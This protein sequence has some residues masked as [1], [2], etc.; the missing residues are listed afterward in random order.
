MEQDILDLLKRSDY[1]PANIAGIRQALGLKT[2]RLTALK[3][4]VHR[5]ERN[6][7][8][9]RI[10]G[11]RYIIPREAD[12]V[13]GRLQVTRSGRGFLIPDDES[14]EEVAIPAESTGT[15]L[16]E[17]KVLARINP[18]SSRRGGIDQ[19]PSGVVVRVLERRRSQFVGT[20]GRSRQ[21]V[22][23]I[24]DDPR[25]PYDIYVPEPHDVGRPA[26]AGDKVVV[27]LTEWSSAHTRPEGEV[28]EVL[29]EATKEGVDM[30]SVIR[31]YELPLHFPKP[32]LDEVKTLGTSVNGNDVKGRVD[33]RKHPVIT[34]DPVDAK[35]FDDAFSLVATSDGNWKLMVHIADV[36]Y[37]VKRGSPLDEEARK[38]GNSTYLVDRVI[39]M[40]PEA[41]SNELCSLKPQ[42]DRL[43][44]CVEFTL[45]PK[46]NVLRSKCL[47]AVIHSQHRYTYEEA[48]SVLERKPEND[49]EQMLHAASKLA[50]QIRKRRFRS[51]A[52]ELEFPENKIYLDAQGRVDR[53]VQCDY[54]VSHQLIE[55]FMLLANEAVAEKLKRRRTPTVYRIHEA[56]DPKRL[57]DY[58]ED[59]KAH[60]IPCGNL[61]KPGEVQKLMR[62][63]NESNVGKA[64]KIGFLKALM[65]ARYSTAPVG[66]YGLAKEDYTHFT[67]PIRRYADL[68]VHRSLFEK[69]RQA[70]LRE[71]SDHISLT[72]R[73]SA[74]AER[75]SHS[76]KLFAHLE[77]QLATDKRETYSGLITEIR[78]FGFFVDVSALGLSG[79]VPLSSVEDEFF[80]FHRERRLLVGQRTGRQIKLGDEIE[81][82]VDKVDA[83]KKQVDFRL[84]RSPG[85]T[86]SKESRSWPQGSKHKKLRQGR[87]KRRS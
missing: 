79:L 24:P 61:N 34:I 10:K 51:G 59:V 37:Y 41:L 53:I 50:Q 70:D 12:L 65:R 71:I 43:T 76:V 66:H 82:E 55:E 20:L 7:A 87:R 25:I 45:D 28:I 52:L 35:D 73:N 3:A 27:E 54:D 84:K 29:G 75:D 23:V 49:R 38:R 39:P 1:S 40:L 78:N 32:I 86:K 67:S 16:H 9:A 69:G 18:V 11:N 26:R 36:S 68:I 85:R 60:G 21:F 42:V 62:R 14:L 72:E 17:D 19:R 8:I 46:G 81:V 77:Q 56:P 33:C 64:L 13:P 15:A 4:T 6:G 47:S 5:L 63:L 80:S 83:F 74:D 58:R 44:K 22:F 2:G 48:L 31:H 57:D 30:L